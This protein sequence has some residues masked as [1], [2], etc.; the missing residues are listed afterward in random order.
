MKQSIRESVFETNSS[1]SHSLT[2]FDYKLW[3]DCHKGCGWFNYYDGDIYEACPFNV[4][5][6]LEDIG[7]VMSSDETIPETERFAQ[8]VLECL[9]EN[10]IYRLLPGTLN[11]IAY[12]YDASI[13][14]QETPD[15]KYMGVAIYTSD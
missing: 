7:A 1:S 9:E 4:E 12:R 13:E 2:Y 14:T 8:A 5:S 11:E 15:Q 3:M 10:A 6:L